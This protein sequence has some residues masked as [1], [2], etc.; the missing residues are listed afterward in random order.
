MD[1]ISLRNPRVG[2]RFSLRYADALLSFPAVSSLIWA[3]ETVIA[4]WGFCNGGRLETPMLC[5]S[6]LIWPEEAPCLG[7]LAICGKKM[8]LLPRIFHLAVG[9]SRGCETLLPFPAVSSLFGKK[10]R[11]NRIVFSILRLDH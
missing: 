4:V 1:A 7:A 9:G 5:L 6:N 3:R 8:S 2:I 11:L 10:N